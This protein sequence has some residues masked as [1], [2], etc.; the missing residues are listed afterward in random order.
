MAQEPHL[1]M[2]G[3]PGPWGLGS[4]SL[5]PHLTHYHLPRPRVPSWAQHLHLGSHDFLHPGCPSLPAGEG[6]PQTGWCR[7]TGGKGNIC[8]EGE[9]RPLRPA[10]AH[11]GHAH[12]HVPFPPC[13]GGQPRCLPSVPIFTKPHTPPHDRPLDTEGVGGGNPNPCPWG[14]RSSH[15]VFVRVV[16]VSAN[17]VALG[18]AAGPER[19]QPSAVGGWLSTARVQ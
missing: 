15:C 3:G 1:G 14:S 10:W 19:G 17:L 12:W 6:Q 16:W 9:G 18:P 5:A 8:W 2:G 11:A 4:P 7:R 13:P